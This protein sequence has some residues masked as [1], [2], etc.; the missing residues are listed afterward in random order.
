MRS[1]ALYA[2]CDLCVFVSETK[3]GTVQSELYAYRDVEENIVISY[4]A[5]TEWNPTLKI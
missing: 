3:R 4:E 5:S 1:E 2:T